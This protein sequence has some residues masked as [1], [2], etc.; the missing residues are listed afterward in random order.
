MITE[1]IINSILDTDFYKITMGEVVFHHFPLAEAEYTFIDRSK[2]TYPLGFD[3]ALKNQIRFLSCFTLT[4]EETNYL[5]SIPFLRPTYIDWLSHYRFNPDE[6]E[7]SQD[8][9]G[10]LSIKIRGPWYKTIYWEVPLMAIISELYFKMNNITPDQLS[11]RRIIEKAIN[12][13]KNVCHWIDFGTRRR[14]SYKIQDMVVKHMSKYVGFLGTSNPHFAR[15]YGV[16]ANGTYAHESIM[17]MS[18]LYGPRMANKT[19]MKLWAE[20]FNGNVG[21][22]LTD[23]FTTDVFLRDFDAYEARL[24]DGVRQD[25]GDPI[26]WGNKMINHYNHL[27]IPTKNKRLVF[28]DG[29]TTQKYIAID[30]YFRDVAQ[31]CGGIGT[32]FTNDVGT[33]TPLNIVVK[34]T[35]LNGIDVVKLSDNPGKHTGNPEEIERVKEEL[36]IV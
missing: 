32:H 28:S 36:K 13:E 9:L 19:W 8:N 27:G 22:S 24:F 12:L 10:R 33:A 25:S 17:A 21:I 3:V 7:I 20:H 14:F 31:P 35:A 18:A 15:K 11:E 34:L 5:R 26:K 23:T 16:R 4:N 2:F 30:K 29:L 6:V 1:P